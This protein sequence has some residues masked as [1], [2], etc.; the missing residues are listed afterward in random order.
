M[1]ERCISYLQTENLLRQWPTIQGIR[2][3]LAL[4]LKSLQGGASLVDPNDYI[5]TKVIGNKVIT[6][7]SFSGGISDTTGNLATSYSNQIARDFSETVDCI[8][9]EKFY[10]GLVDNKLDI[11]C[12]RITPIQYEILKLFYW[13][14]KVWADVLEELKKDKKFMSKKSAQDQRRDAIEKIRSISKVSVKAYEIVMKLAG[15]E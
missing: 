13:E 4:E 9:N 7:N 11:A 14:D 1:A 5:H 15:V 8:Q 6:G 3:S 2:E 10:I 12:K